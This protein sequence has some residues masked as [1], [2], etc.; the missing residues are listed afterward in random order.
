MHAAIS[1]ERN[2]SRMKPERFERIK[3]LQQKY[4]ASGA[5]QETY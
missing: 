1:G 5:Y 2:G 3:A 4:S